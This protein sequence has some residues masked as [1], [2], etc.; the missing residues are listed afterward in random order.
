MSE[1]T[2]RT[3]STTPAVLDPK[4]RRGAVGKAL[5]VWLGTGSVGAAIIAY[6]LFANMGC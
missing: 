6:L 1:T 4:A 3:E 2:E 5:L